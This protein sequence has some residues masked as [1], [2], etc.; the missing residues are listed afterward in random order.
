MAT[1]LEALNEPFRMRKKG[2]LVDPTSFSSPGLGDS[3]LA[4]ATYILRDFYL[5][6]P[7][8]GYLE[9]DVPINSVAAQASYTVTAISANLVSPEYIRYIRHRNNY[10]IEEKDQE[11]YDRYYNA[12]D[13]YRVIT[14]PNTDPEIWYPYKDTINFYPAFQTTQTA[15]AT[16]FFNKAFNSDLTTADLSLPLIIPNHNRNLFTNA[17]NMALDELLPIG[18]PEMIA[19]YNKMMSDQKLVTLIRHKGQT[20]I[21]IAK[22]MQDVMGGLY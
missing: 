4:W 8:A 14:P 15:A 2:K 7:D 17:I 5:R 18:A 13:N 9:D 21:E 6:N 22:E 3:L 20:R 1:L 12:S 19:R 11:T 16:I 10:I